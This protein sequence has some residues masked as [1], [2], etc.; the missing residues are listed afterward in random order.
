MVVVHRMGTLETV[1]LAAGAHFAVASAIL[2]ARSPD[3]HR[4]KDPTEMLRPPLNTFEIERYRRKRP[5]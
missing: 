1:P 2:F 4:I 3:T 5:S